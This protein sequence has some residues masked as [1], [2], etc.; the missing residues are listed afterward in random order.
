MRLWLYIK[1]YKGFI[2]SGIFAAFIIFFL[3]FGENFSSSPKES[4]SSN[5]L[6]FLS[7]AWQAEAISAVRDMVAEWN[8]SHPNQ[9]VELI[10]GTW[11]SVHD[12]LITGFETGDI[13]DVFHYESAIIVDFALRGY[14]SDLSPMVKSQMKTDIIAPAWESVTRSSG[15]IIGIPFIAESFIVLYNKKLFREAGIVPPS[16]DRPWSWDDLEKAARLLTRDMNQD[17]TTDQWGT[18]MGLRS[19]ANLI[20]NHSIGFNGTYFYENDEGQIVTKVGDGEKELLQKILTMLYDDKSMAPASVGLSSSGLMPGFLAGKYATLVGVGA[21]ARQQVIE[22]AAADFE[23]G[24][25]PPLQAK[26]QATGL[27]TQTFSIPKRSHK[28]KDA[29]AFLEFLVSPENMSRLAATDWL[30]PTRQSLLEAPQFNSEDDGWK[31]VSQSAQYLSSGP[32][33]GMPGYIEWKS[34]VANPVFQ[35]LFAGRISLDKA[36]ERIERESNSVLKRYQI[37]GLK[38]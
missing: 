5:T 37:R 9:P 30:M 31:V 7:L 36:S 33:T 2:L 10:Q 19:A 34:R 32:W 13:P 28:Q 25:L 21:W 4:A 3:F 12:Y 22:N 15:E 6:K 38:W 27:N 16:F 23:W 35:E 26:T 18:A 11:N 1:L 20:M 17:G 8:E 24:V 14:L 29:M